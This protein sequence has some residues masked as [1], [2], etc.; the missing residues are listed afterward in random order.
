MDVR[1]YMQHDATALAALVA[2]GEIDAAGLLALA[3]ER[4][5]EVNPRINAVIRSMEQIADTRA[6]QPL[7]GPFAGVPFLIKDL[8]QEY[9]GVP[10]TYGSRALLANFATEHSTIVQRFLD[11][12]LVI[13]GKTNVPEFGAK[14]ITESDLFGPARNPWDTTRTPGG[15]SGGSAA[16]V[17]AGI[18]PAAGANDGGGSIRIPAGCCGLV[19][20]KAGRGVMPFGPTMGE[21]LNG[22]AIQGFV[23]RSVRDS[24]AL[25]DA[26]AGPEPTWTYLPAA[27]AQ[28]ALE[29]I[30]R[31]PGKLRIGYSAASAI[32]ANPHPE[33]VVAVES[34]AALLSELGHDVEEIAP[35]YD[36]GALALDFLT[37]WF[38]VVVAEVALT[39]RTFG[40]VDRD[41]EA[42]TLAMAELGRA[43]GAI[44]AAEAHE[45]THLYVRSIA[46][47]HE[48][49]DYFLTPTMAEPPIAVD[50]LTTPEA[51]QVGS[52]V[53]AKVHGGAL[54][55]VLPIMDEMIADNLGWVPYTQLANVTGRPA[56]NVP[57]YWTPEGLPMGVQFVGTL[58]SEGALLQLAAQLEQA[59][60]WAQRH[61]A[62]VA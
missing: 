59:S 22:M 49:Y 44:K 33:A 24:A 62:P 20:L 30:E 23:S 27:P 51:M 18:V 32:N 61:P 37:I 54:L 35:P 56:I 3:R 31:P 2:A 57:L 29:M 19:G 21:P 55:K 10:T 15:S 9:A 17:A 6:A 13:F 46:E 43:N 28:P 52:R 39:K 60:P 5:A 8:A 25:F 47:F 38:A 4:A 12:G 45:N 53:L 36:D 1:D 40:A 48:H 50:R 41:F 34:A 26:T 11:A 42:D 7:E 14:G 58:G 16:A